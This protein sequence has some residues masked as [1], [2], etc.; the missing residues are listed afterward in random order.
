MI[1]GSPTTEPRR[2]G[3]GCGA[4]IGIGCGVILLIG[5]VSCGAA[6]YWM[7]YPGSQLETARVVGSESLAYVEVADLSKSEAAVE[8]LG[9]TLEHLDRQNPNRQNT[10]EWM[11]GLEG[12]SQNDLRSIA[13][14]IAPSS[15]SMSIEADSDG[16][17]RAVTA[18]NFQSFPR[19]AKFL[20]MNLPE[21]RDGFHTTPHRDNTIYELRNGGAFV[22]LEST[23]LMSGDMDLLKQAIDRMSDA[24]VNAPLRELDVPREGSWDVRGVLSPEASTWLGLPPA[25][26]SR[27]AARL[28]DADTGT[29][30]VTVLCDSESAAQG[31]E[32]TLLQLA[33]ERVAQALENELELE[34]TITRKGTQVDLDV[35]LKGLR[36]YLRSRA[37]EALQ[38]TDSSEDTGEEEVSEEEPRPESD[39]ATPPAP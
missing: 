16:K 30:Y 5:L 10:P 25:A 39:P 23:L 13:Q 2:G 28:V 11:R 36:D 29:G 7:Y 9:T 20:L 17:P 26:T 21:D 24:P 32:R 35:T 3:M 34:F 1:P 4:M 8:L 33:E 22:F 15:V 18:V 37:D 31:A 38:N 27:M 12:S 6:S 14:R 19:L